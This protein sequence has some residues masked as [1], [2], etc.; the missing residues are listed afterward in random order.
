M[1]KKV[2]LWTL[3]KSRAV[4]P[5]HIIHHIQGFHLMNHSSKDGSNLES[6]GSD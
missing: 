2:S 6:E 5:V 4:L 3:A 1:E